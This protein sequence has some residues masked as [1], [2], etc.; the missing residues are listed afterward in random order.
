MS[1]LTTTDSNRPIRFFVEM[2]SSDTGTTL[3]NVFTN[4]ARSSYADCNAVECG[5]E[6]WTY[7]EL[8]AI[9]TG[10]ALE[11]HKSY[12]LKPVVAIV[13]ENNPYILATIFATWKLGGV[14]AP[15]DTNVPRDIMERMLFNIG[16]TFVLLPSAQL[17]VQNVVKGLCSLRFFAFVSLNLFQK[18]PCHTLLFNLK[19]LL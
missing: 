11:M 17:N 3:L 8:D 15:M 13:S 6:R 9:S 2:A 10:I 5:A 12:G 14:V 7:G 19:I 18:T 16:P 1:S 4:I